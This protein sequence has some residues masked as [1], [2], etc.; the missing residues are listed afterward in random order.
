MKPAYR[1]PLLLSLVLAAFALRVF[2]LDRQSLW[3]DEVDAIYFAV[4][5]LDETLSMFVQAAQNGP[6]YF[7]G[8]RPWFAL[9]GTWEFV[10]RFPSAVAGTLSIPLL[11]QVGRQLLPE[12]AATQQQATAQRRERRA[13]RRAA[14]GAFVATVAVVLMTF[15]PYQVWYGQ[16]GKMYATIT[17][18]MLLATYFWLRGITRGGAWPWVGYWLTVTVAMYTHLLMVLVIPVHMVW[19]LIAWPASRQHWRGYG[20]ALA[21]LILPYLAHGLV[22][23]VAADRAGEAVRL[24][25]YAAQPGA[26][27]AAAQPCPWLYRHDPAVMAGAHILSGR[28]RP[29]VGR[30][31]TG[32]AR[33]Q[34]IW[35]SHLGAAWGCCVT[36]LVLPVAFIYLISLRQPVFTERY[37]IWIG[38]AAMLALA[39]GLRVLHANSGRIASGCDRTAAGLRIGRMGLC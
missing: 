32:S 22:A 37:V 28:R 14:A 29:A 13:H 15:N 26:G 5:S 1:R 35:S 2:G 7:L 24:H 17:C 18:L 25:L 23:L 19:F 11:W 38:P 30:R 8:L 9:M 21:G 27:R 20:A 31:P 34:A 36:W 10:L 16:E 39:L 4:R 33:E 12:R 6:L 3:R